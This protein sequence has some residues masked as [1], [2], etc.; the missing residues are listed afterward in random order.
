MSLQDKTDRVENTVSSVSQRLLNERIFPYLL[1]AGA[2]VWLTLIYAYPLARTIWYSFF[3]V[4]L[5]N[6]SLAE[7][8]G[9]Q[10]YEKALTGSF[11][12]TLVRTFIWT[13]GSVIPALLLGM[14]GAM[15]LNREFLGRRWALG[16]ALVP[17]TMPLAIVG[18]IWSMMYHPQIGFLTILFEDYLN[19]SINFLGYDNALRSVIIARI[20]R[21]TPFAMI[22][23]YARLQSIP[24]HLYESAKID[25]A[26]RW[27]QFRYITLPE[28]SRVMMIALIMLTVWT[29]LVFD[30]IWAMTQGGPVNATTIIP[31]D[32]YETIFSSYELG[33]AGAKSVITVGLLLVITAIYW[34]YSDL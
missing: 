27:Q 28:L 26:G 21:A 6:P 11:A 7:F 9:L 2:A 15:L 5:V 18:F 32:I 10:N 12:N 19:M 34:K 1:I 17:W 4:G 29:T 23:I 13:F 31:I 33:M 16:L 24:D 20:W 25:G 22:I 8:V 3:E 30:I 14:V